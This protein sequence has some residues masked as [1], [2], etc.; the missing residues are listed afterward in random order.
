MRANPT[1]HW[2]ANTA[3]AR[4]G[5]TVLVIRKLVGAGPASECQ[6]VMQPQTLDYSKTFPARRTSSVVLVLLAPLS[7]YLVLCAVRSAPSY[8]SLPYHGF[9]WPDNLIMRYE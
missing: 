4:P 7:V 9:P 5:G 8:F 2:T 3:L 1:L 6:P